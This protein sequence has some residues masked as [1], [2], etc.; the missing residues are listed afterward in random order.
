MEDVK[1]ATAEES[2]SRQQETDRLRGEV[3]KLTQ[4]RTEAL[5]HQRGDLVSTYEHLM[6]EREQSYH[7]REKEIVTMISVLENKF[8]VIQTEALQLRSELRNTQTMH[9]CAD[10]ELALKSDQLRALQYKY[11]DDCKARAQEL[12]TANKRITELVSEL[13]HCKLVASNDVS[14]GKAEISK[15]SER[16]WGEWIS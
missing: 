11:D 7:S 12:D 5:E 16:G 13:D 4:A 1:V 15:V 6:K 14:G 8:E 9:E 2:R 3:K 10:H